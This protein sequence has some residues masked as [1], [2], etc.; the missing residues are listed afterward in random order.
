[1]GYEGYEHL[2]ITV[3][4]GICTVRMN[5]PE[6][7]NAFNATMGLEL[8]R[9]PAE[10]RE[11][12]DVRVV[13][14]TGTGRG[15][16]S[17][18]DTAQERG[19]NADNPFQRKKMDELG[20]TGRLPTAWYNIDKPTIAA[21]NGVAAGGGLCLA[22]IQDIRIA[23][24]SARFIPV[25]IKRGIA[26]EV[27]ASWFVS[28]L[29]GLPRALEWFYT[30]DEINGEKAEQIGLANHTVDDDKLMDTAMAL[31]R[32]IA[33]GPPIALRVTRRSV[34]HGSTH[35]LAE[36]L[37]V[38]VMNLA[39]TQATEDAEEGRAAVRERRKANFTGR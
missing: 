6:K 11:D 35:T 21:V 17:G 30:G 15:F 3:E 34:Y 24:R 10:L 19:E 28:R 12:N 26:P 29:I 14:L 31:A 8:L 25:F 5:R 20:Y 16:C 39:I 9:L 13:I 7:L 38:E 4:D 18:V 22:M 37:P 23:A 1:M 27:G 32:Q 36:H 33:D 2:V